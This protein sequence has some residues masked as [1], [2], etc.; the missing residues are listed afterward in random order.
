MSAVRA[1]RTQ[2][3]VVS[4][5]V[6]LADDDRGIIEQLSREGYDSVLRITSKK[7]TVRAN[8][9]HQKDSHI[10]YVLKGKIRYVEQE[11][12]PD[13]TVDR[14]SAQ[15]EY[16]I[17]PGQCFYTAPMIAH[18]MEFLADTEFLAI[19]PRTGNAQE[20]ETDLIRVELI[21]PADAAARAETS[22]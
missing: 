7:G 13:G 2:A 22:F 3:P 14:S 12:L 9:Y 16:I 8:H 6:I 10:C 5:P 20:Y 1:T 19:S 4:D 18:A 15:R 11:L 17:K 21:N